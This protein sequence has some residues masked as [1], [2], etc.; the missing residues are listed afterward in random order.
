MSVMTLKAEVNEHQEAWVCDRIR[1]RETFT[2]TT[3]SGLAVAI[4][5]ETAEVESITIRFHPAET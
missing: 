2:I 5:G 1:N 4:G 3:P